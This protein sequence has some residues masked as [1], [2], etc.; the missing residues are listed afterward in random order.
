MRARVA[1]PRSR[2]GRGRRGGCRARA[3]AGAPRHAPSPRSPTPRRRR[4]P[5]AGRRSD[6]WH[7][8]PRS[9]EALRSS[10]PHAARLP[11]ESVVPRSRGW[12]EVNACLR[13]FT[14][15]HTVAHANQVRQCEAIDLRALGHPSRAAP[16]R[17]GSSSDSDHGRFMVL[18]GLDG[19]L[20]AIAIGSLALAALA[21]LVASLGP[22]SSVALQGAVPRLLAVLG[23]LATALLGAVGLTDRVFST[24]EWWPGFPAQ[25]FTMAADALSAPF[26]LLLGLVGGMSFA[27][28]DGRDSG[29]GARARLALQASFTLAMLSALAS[30]HAL[31]FLF[32]WAGCRSPR[33]TDATAAP[34]RGRGSR[35]RRASRS[36]CS[37]RW[38]R[39][40]RSSSSS[41][42][43]A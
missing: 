6:T 14:S 20:L 39:S 2:P 16:G 38:R 24:L 15:A 35:S 12:A 7:S 42:G 13:L 43:R 5:R 22:R 23:C 25:P 40:T 18:A 1:R 30:Q 9:R 37:P 36:P 11:E 32:S 41:R 26:L 17:P 4:T 29:T 21:P 3:R 28:L 19:A 31:L 34:G 27:S 33:S 8:L 10:T